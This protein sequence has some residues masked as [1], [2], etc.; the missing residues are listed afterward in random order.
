MVDKYKKIGEFLCPSKE[1]NVFEKRVVI[2]DYRG[3]C[4]V[5]E[6][7]WMKI[8]GRQNPERWKNKADVA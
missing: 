8:W 7:E 2:Q 6:R 4:V 5:S 3:A 1:P